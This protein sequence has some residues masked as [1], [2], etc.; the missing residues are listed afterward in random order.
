LH[1]SNDYSQAPLRFGFE[2]EHGSVKAHPF[3]DSVAELHQ[4]V[5]GKLR[6]KEQIGTPNSGWLTEFAEIMHEVAPFLSDYG[7]SSLLE[8]FAVTL[9]E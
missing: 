9:A 2:R 4:H 7:D 6:L 3:N 1:S 8:S 5:R